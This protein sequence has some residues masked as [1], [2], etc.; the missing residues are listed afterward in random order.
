MVDKLT[1]VLSRIF[2]TVAFILFLIAAS[3]WLLRVF[4]W[5]WSWSGYT[6][7]RLFELSAI[8]M[9]FVVVL[10]LRQIRERLVTPGK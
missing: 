6:P 8:L 2:F 10:L 1:S 7:G 4:G 5:T 3:D 9:I